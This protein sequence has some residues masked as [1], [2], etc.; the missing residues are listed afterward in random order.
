MLSVLES[1]LSTRACL[2]TLSSVASCPSPC[3]CLSPCFGSA[4]PRLNAPSPY[5]LIRPSSRIHF[6]LHPSQTDVC[7][8]TPHPSSA[9]DPRR[10]RMSAD[11]AHINL[12]IVRRPSHPPQWH[13]HPLTS[14]RQPGTHIATLIRSPARIL[15][16]HSVRRLRTHSSHSPFA[17]GLR[18]LCACHALPS[19]RISQSCSRPRSP[20]GC[21]GMRSPAGWSLY[22]VMALRYRASPP[23]VASGFGE[24][25]PYPSRSSNG[26]RFARASAAAARTPSRTMAS[27][28]SATL[29]VKAS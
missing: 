7:P 27:T 9:I 11:L 4:N 10:R 2:S 1:R 17:L 19:A 8:L 15:S 14:H 5:S 6:S 16:P 21:E 25:S 22:F 18:Q 3:V 20:T 26:R 28:S 29:L 23:K 12:A 24:S 13:A